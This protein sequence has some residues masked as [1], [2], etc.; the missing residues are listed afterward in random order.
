MGAIFLYKKNAS[1]DI[2]AVLS[3]FKEKGFTEPHNFTCSSYNILLYKKIGINQPNFLE[4]GEN[5]IYCVGTFIYKRSNYKDSLANL[6]LDLS[7]N[8][9]SPDALLGNFLILY[10]SGNKLFYIS[11]R[12]G[13]QNIFYNKDKSVITSSFLACVNSFNTKVTVNKHA[14]VEVLT[15]GTLIGSET[16]FNEIER[17][18]VSHPAKFDELEPIKYDRNPVPGICHKKYDSCMDEQINVLDNY[19]SSIKNFADEMKVDSGI[20]GGHD[21]RLIMAL[22]LKHFK[23]ISF[24][25]HWRSEKNVE[26]DAAQELCKVTNADLK[27]IPVKNPEE[28]SVEELESNFKDAFLFFDGLIKMHSFWTEEYNTRS[29]REKVLG[30]RRLGLS[31]IGGEQYRNEERMNR[32]KWKVYNI[33]KYKILLNT[34]GDCFLDDSSLEDTISYIESKF[35][36]ILGIGGK[37]KIN[38]LEYKRYLNDVFVPGRLSARNNA[39]NQLSFFLSPFTDHTV[40]TESYRVVQILGPSLQFEEEMIKKIDPKIAS[41]PSDHGFDF[42]N[43][44]PLT[45]KLKS[46]FI[47]FVPVSVLYRYY[48]KKTFKKDSSGLFDRLINKSPLISEGLMKL[49]E[50]KLSINLKKLSR[51]P[52]LMPLILAMGY[53][54][55]RL[56]GK[57]AI[58]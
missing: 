7:E 58:K 20:T 36:N 13:I 47:D 57:I 19:F 52:D 21:S 38:R 5:S 33:I 27:L 25:T 49:E 10:R 34:C 50:L 51:K 12:S 45:G 32:S 16:L 30:D 37:K 41:V 29:Y 15:T 24:N 3:V 6:L 54:L 17:F 44:E 35:R 42:F 43:G 9:F 23:D 55:K 48:V 14:A 1:I 40:S 18:E 39:E 11:D 2:N 46:F 53:L 8:N 26:F 31:G 28:M 56:E 4:I 22:A